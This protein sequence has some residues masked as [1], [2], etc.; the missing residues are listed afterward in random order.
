[1][2]RLFFVFIL[3]IVILVLNFIVSCCRGVSIVLE[4]LLL[5]MV[6]IM[7]LIGRVVDLGGI[8][9]MGILVM[10]SVVVVMLLKIIFFKFVVFLLLSMSIFILCFFIFCLNKVKMGF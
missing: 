7:C 3:S 4:I 2:V 6:S 8:M 9:K 1:M 5:F 10:L